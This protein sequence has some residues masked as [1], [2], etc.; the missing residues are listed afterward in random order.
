MKELNVFSFTEYC[1]PFLT[2]IS[3]PPNP[4]NKIIFIS[5][6]NFWCRKINAISSRVL[7]VKMV[8]SFLKR[9]SLPLVPPETAHRNE[10][11]L[12]VKDSVSFT[13]L[14]IGLI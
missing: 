9:N 2:T 5:E 8:L 10:L 12:R 4:E 3:I 1:I 14:I 13:G 6:E 7:T 11:P